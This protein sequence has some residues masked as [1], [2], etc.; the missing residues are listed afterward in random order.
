MGV[1]IDIVFSIQMNTSVVHQ[2][3]ALLLEPV[4]QLVFNVKMMNTKE[5]IPITFD[6]PPDKVKGIF[7]VMVC[8]ASL[9][10]RWVWL[11]LQCSW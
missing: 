1:A 6:T 7:D 8:V 11:Q 3:G 5:A 4:N 2:S 9:Q 10:R